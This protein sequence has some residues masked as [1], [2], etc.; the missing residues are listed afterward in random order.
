MKKEKSC[1]HLLFRFLQ[2]EH[3]T[4]FLSFSFR[5]T[6]QMAE[7]M[8]RS[9]EA[10]GLSPLASSSPA[11]VLSAS[12]V[13]PE[14]AIVGESHAGGSSSGVPPDP[15]VFPAPGPTDRSSS[16]HLALPAPGRPHTRLLRLDSLEQ[17]FN[18]LGVNGQAVAGLSAQVRYYSITSSFM[19]IEA[20]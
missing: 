8:N 13:E 6:F 20:T 1:T 9:A 7:A 5:T 10:A 4:N 12:S 2:E 3:R 18:D 16:L 11:P 19:H 14:V 17:S 15:L